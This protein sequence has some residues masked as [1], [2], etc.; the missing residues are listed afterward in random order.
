VSP[1]PAELASLVEDLRSPDPAVRDE[2]AYSA[3]AHRAE[4]G[5]LDDHLPELAERAAALLADEAVQGRTFGA[6][7]VALVVD[8]DNVTGR[9]GEPVVRR[10]LDAVLRWYVAEPDTRGFDAG[11]GW[12]HA[13]AHGA[14]ALGELAD[15]PRLGR[16]DLARVLDA[17]VRRTVAVT[18]QHWLQDEDDRVAVAVMGVLRRDLLDDEEVRRAV[19]SLATAWRT[20]QPGPIAAGTD[21]AVRLARTLHLQLTLGVRS[22]PDG[23]VRHP[24]ARAAALAALGG[25]LAEQHWFYGTP[26]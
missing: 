24:A 17:L 11:L 3:L 12:L 18:D 13:V 5:K 10:L 26:A 20:A 15:S 14:D 6:L 19:D 22:E 7:L 23:P 8:R 2:G 16:P 21:N 4:E 9:A 25:A 1:L